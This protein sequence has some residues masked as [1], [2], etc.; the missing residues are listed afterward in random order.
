ML[1]LLAINIGI[2]MITCQ[3]C[4]K[5]LSQISSSHLRIHGI[6]MAEYKTQFPDAPLVSVEVAQKISNKN[7]GKP[8]SDETKAKLSAAKKGKPAHNKGVRTGPLSDETKAKMSQAHKGKIHSSETKAKIGLAHKGKVCLP[9]T[10]DRLKKYVEENGSAFKGKHHSEKAKKI[11]SEKATGRKQSDETKSKKS[12][13]L[14]GLQRTDEQKERYS[15]ARLKYMNENPR[16]LHNTAGEIK[17]REW[18]ED[19]GITYVQQFTLKPYGHPYDFF[20]PDYNTIIEFDGC[21]HWMRPWWNVKDKNEKEIQLEL[22]KQMEKDAVE[23]LD[24]GKKGYK[25]I[26]IRGG[27]TVGDIGNCGSLEEQLKLQGFNI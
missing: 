11:L 13:A 14:L 5:E 19:K 3:I 15:K 12:Q 17:I 7:K 25:I 6:T 26:R 2:I 9:E 20:L 16:K 1:G 18:L 22:D 27:S 23:N 10:A 8:K 4:N 21:H 24:A